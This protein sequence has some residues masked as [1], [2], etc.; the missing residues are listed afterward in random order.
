MW[1]GD[2]L[3]VGR[4]S[5]RDAIVVGPPLPSVR[6]FAHTIIIIEGI[7]VAEATAASD[8]IARFGR[9]VMENYLKFHARCMCVH[10]TS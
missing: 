2:A 1:C 7:I 5:R 8:A 6:V 3:V 4:T 9:M 10:T